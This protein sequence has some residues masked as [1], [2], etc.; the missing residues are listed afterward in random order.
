MFLQDTPVVSGKVVII[1]WANGK[2]IP[3]FATQLII[4]SIVLQS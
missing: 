4:S 1:M 3:R 2:T